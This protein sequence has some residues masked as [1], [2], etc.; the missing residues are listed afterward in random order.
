MFV[1]HDAIKWPI[2]EGE[3]RT[4]NTHHCQAPPTAGG[5][6]AVTG[7]PVRP[8]HGSGTSFLEFAPLPGAI[9]CARLHTVH[10]LHEWDLCALAD[11]AAL[12]VSEL[13]T[14]AVDASVVLPERPPITL[15]LL[16]SERSLLIEVWDQSPLDLE[17]RE[18]EPDA[19]CGRGLTVVAALSDRWVWERTSYNRKVVRAEF[20]L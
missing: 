4:V 8:E 5:T 17:P 2:V 11:D 7:R 9:P 19:E 12:V 13:M 1:G 15:R 6:G 16:A 14:N 10:V 20:A 3:A 18:A